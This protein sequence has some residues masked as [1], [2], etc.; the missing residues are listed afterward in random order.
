MSRTVEEIRQYNAEYR[1][2]NRERL[3]ANKKEWYKKQM[4]LYGKIVRPSKKVKIKLDKEII[5]EERRKYFRDYYLSHKP[6]KQPKVMKDIPEEL[7]LVEIV[8][9]PKII[10]AE[11]DSLYEELAY[12]SPYDPEYE[13]TYNKINKANI[14]LAGFT[15]S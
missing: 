4:E 15:M 13:K 3:I 7:A 10:E 11:I 5:I 8:K 6:K 2:K 9:D 12:I 1:Y 14:K